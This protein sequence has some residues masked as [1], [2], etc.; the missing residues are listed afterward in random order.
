[1]MTLPVIVSFV[2]LVSLEPGC[3][4]AVISIRLVGMMLS[5][6]VIFLMWLAFRTVSVWVFSWML[7]LLVIRVVRKWVDTVF[8]TVWFTSWLVVLRIAILSFV[9]WVI[10]VNLSLTNFLLT[11]IVWCVRVTV[12]CRW[13]VLV[14][15]CSLRMFGR[16]SLL[17]GGW[18]ACVLA[19][20]IRRLKLRCLLLLRIILVVRW[21]TVEMWA[22]G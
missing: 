2:V 8:A 20:R 22:T 21:L 6:S 14:R 7:M 10:E 11:I 4:L 1:M 3:M 5:L 17:R 13:W 12:L 9:V 19:V 15:L 16:L 18:T